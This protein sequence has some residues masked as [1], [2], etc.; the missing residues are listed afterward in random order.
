MYY[1]IY[2]LYIPKND[3]RVFTSC[4]I[5]NTGKEILRHSDN[6]HS[7]RLKGH[8]YKKK[9]TEK[10]RTDTLAHALT[11]II[12]TVFVLDHCSEHKDPETKATVLTVDWVF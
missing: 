7:H 2:R 4:S 6:F 1:R 8:F 3:A 11:Q 10:K 5:T 9:K 12:I